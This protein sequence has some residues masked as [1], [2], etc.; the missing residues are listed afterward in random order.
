MPVQDSTYRPTR[1]GR[2]LHRQQGRERGQSVEASPELPSAEGSDAPVWSGIPS[3]CDEPRI[4]V[5]HGGGDEEEVKH[6]DVIHEG[7]ACGVDVAWHQDSTQ[8]EDREHSHDQA[9]DDY[10]IELRT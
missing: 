7:Q 1:G 6:K 8:W 2:P 9:A 4:L 3:C 5:E 10:G